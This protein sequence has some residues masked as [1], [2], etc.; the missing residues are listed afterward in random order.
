MGR[1]ER[2]NNHRSINEVSDQSQ[3]GCS[4]QAVVVDG[5][6]VVLVAVVDV[7]SH[8]V[9]AEFLHLLALAL[10]PISSSEASLNKL[11][12]GNF[13]FW[14]GSDPALGLF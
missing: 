6:I 3:W 4:S 2:I 13:S 14:A 9:C 10:A 8:L 11:E 5:V 1:R 7:V 12:R